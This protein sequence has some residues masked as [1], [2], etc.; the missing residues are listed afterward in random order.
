MIVDLTADRPGDARFIT[1][2]GQVLIQTSG[3]TPPGGYPD[4]PFEATLEDG[5]FG[6]LFLGIRERR[7][8]RVKWVD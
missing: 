6:S 1:E 4:V 3:G 7:R 5:A 2:T 8:I